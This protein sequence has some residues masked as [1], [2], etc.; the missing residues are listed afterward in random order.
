MR[1]RGPALI[2]EDR[3]GVSL[4]LVSF[5]LG[6]GATCANDTIAAGAGGGAE[7]SFV[8]QFTTP[9]HY[10]A[11]TALEGAASGRTRRSS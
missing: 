4:A 8:A 10:V 3:A 6:G 9:W 1:G 5:V 11:A 7:L 2:D